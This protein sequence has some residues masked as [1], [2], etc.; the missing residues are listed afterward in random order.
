VRLR[1]EVL[2]TAHPYREWSQQRGW[3]SGCASRL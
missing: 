3:R 1:H 2:E